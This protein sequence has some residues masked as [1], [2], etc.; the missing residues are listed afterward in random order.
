MGR[1]R[2]YDISAARRDL[3]N[4]PVVSLTAGTAE[5]AAVSQREPTSHRG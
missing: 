3:H 1:D 2:S 5:M 4:T